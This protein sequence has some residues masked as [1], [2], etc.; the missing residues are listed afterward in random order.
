MK[1]VNV[2][3]Q[4]IYDEASSTF[5][6]IEPTTLRLE[7]SLQA[8]SKWESKW[9]KPFLDPTVTKTP[10]E[11]LDYIR[12]M[13]V[14]PEDDI[15][16]NVWKAISRKDLKE[17]E[18]YISN[19]MTATTVSNKKTGKAASKKMTSELLYYYM[20][21]L[22]IPFDCDSWHLS[23]LLM[24]IQVAAVEQQGPKKMPKNEMISQRNE[25]NRI[26]QAKMRKH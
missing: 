17:I 21:A 2:P 16:P 5:Y 7:H 6:D 25:L 11:V 9:K 26:R 14:D 22:G 1:I 8:I 20:S 13:L 10:D 15:D 19:S 4:K 23:R 3:E 18:M 12:C 24:L